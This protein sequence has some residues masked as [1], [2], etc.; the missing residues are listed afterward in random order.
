MQRSKVIQSYVDLYVD[1]NY[2]EVG[3]SHGTTFHAV[4][5]AKKVAVDP[6]FQ[7]PSGDWESTSEYHEITSDEYF[8]SLKDEGSLFEVIYL[9]GLHTFEQTLRD[10]MN[11]INLLRRDGVIIVDDVL[12]DSYHS[13]LPDVR[14]HYAVKAAVAANDHSWMGDTYRLVYFVQSFLP[15]FDYATVEDNH[16]QLVLWRGKRK[17]GLFVERKVEDIARLDFRHIVMQRPAYNFLQNY[18]IITRV[19]EARMK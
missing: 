7:I 8:L 17:P 15:M 19:K 1:A 11:A 14:E 6:K 9:D 13:S 12:P 10:L 3:V 16:G 5:A 4:K 2:L 18:E